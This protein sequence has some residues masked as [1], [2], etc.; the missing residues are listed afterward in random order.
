MAVYG[1]ISEFVLDQGTGV[2]M[3]SGWEEYCER[4]TQ[5]F[6]ANAIDGGDDTGKARQKAIFLSS[7]GAEVYSLLKTLS[8]PNKPETKS[9][10]DLQKLVL[11]HL[12]PAPIVIAERY[13][14]YNRK[15]R[16]GENAAEF[17]K[18]LRRLAATCEFPDTFREEVIRDMLVIGLRDRETQ[19]K[20]LRKD[21]LTLDTAF[22]EAQAMER[23][24]SQIDVMTNEVHKT[25]ISHKGKPTYSSGSGQNGSSSSSQHKTRP[26]FS[27]G[28]VGHWKNQ[29][30]KKSS[31]S[32]RKT[33]YKKVKQVVNGPVSDESEI[34]E[35][36]NFANVVRMS[37]VD[38]TPL[39]KTVRKVPE[40][41]VDVCVCGS[42]I[43][44]E[45]DTGAS[46]SLISKN[47]YE[48]LKWQ[49]KIVPSN[50]VLST[51]TGQA[52][53]VV[54]ECVVS[55][56]Y[57]EKAYDNMTIF[58]V[59]SEGPPL[60]GRD[61]LARIP[62]D[63]PE[64]K[65]V[66]QE[67]TQHKIAEVKRKYSKLFDGKLGKVEGVTAK[68]EL[69]ED[70]V[71]K[72]CKPR[73][74]PFATKD[75][76]AAEIAALV[77]SGV[78]K[79]VDYSDWASPIVPV[80]KPSG[81]LRICGDF[82]VTVNKFLKIPEHPMPRVS[83][84]LAK[85]NG[86]QKFT[87]LDLS[88]AYQQVPLDEY[89]QKLVTINTHLGLFS[90]TR[91][92]F[93]ISAA[94]ALFQ[95]IMDKVLQGLECGCYLDDIVITGRSDAEHWK[96]LTLVLER[97]QRF[98]FR[99]QEA[100]CEF[101]QDSVKYLGQVV[102]QKGI[103]MDEEGVT[104]VKSA[105]EPTNKD[106]LRSFLG[107]VSHYRRFIK[108]VSTKCAP[109]NR[110]LRKDERW[111]WSSSC[112]E[113]FDGMKRDLA[114][115]DNVLVHYDPQAPLILSVDASPTGLGAVISH[116]TADGDRPIEFASRSLTVAEKN[117]SQIDREALAIMFGVRKFHQYLYGRKFVLWTD[118]KPLSHI[119]ALKKGIPGLAAARV[120]RWCLELSAYTY[121]VKH[122][123]ASTQGNV[124]ALSRLPLSEKDQQADI[125]GEEARAVNLVALTSL[126]VTA[127]QITQGTRTDPVLS[128]VTHF[129]RE[130]WPNEIQEEWKPFHKRRMELS[131]EEDCLLWGMRV[132][133]PG[134]FRQQLLTLLH[135]GHPGMV[136]M[137]SLARK[138]CWWPLL[139][140][141]IEDM[142]RRCDTCTHSL[143]L[144]SSTT[145]N[146]A[147]PNGP[148]QR[149][150]LDFA[151]YRQDH[152]MVMVDAH[153]KWPE[154]I[155]MPHGTTAKATI[156]ALRAVFGRYGL[157]TTVVSDNGPPFPSREFGSFLQANGI[158]QIFSPPYHP[159]TNGEAERFVRTF[160]EGMNRRLRT[161][162]NKNLC[163]HEFLLT[164]RTT[165]HTTTGITPSEAMFGRNIRTK[166]DLIR[167]D[168]ANS[169]LQKNPGH[170]EVKGYVV[171]ER[172]VVR[173]YR[174]RK[175]TWQEGVVI[176]K[177]SP[178]TYQVEIPSTEGMVIWKR[179]ADQM[180]S[181]GIRT[182]LERSL[183]V[184]DDRDL[185]KPELHARPIEI[186][187]EERIDD[188]P[189]TT[190]P[191][192][193]TE[194]QETG[195]RAPRAAPRPCVAAPADDVVQPRRSNR[196]R[197]L[198][199]YLEDNY[200]LY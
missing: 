185:G 56:V 8:S 19:R 181:S 37:K 13:V 42:M 167:P 128:R 91:V 173:D 110:L 57:K 36:S 93:G 41:M 153:S 200:E 1:H 66:Q 170:K 189:R 35:P 114:E 76:I 135:E 124:D 18:E 118:N 180:R 84:L 80:R 115:P 183:P 39:V 99:L 34:E 142:I 134:K 49:V 159:Q 131:I 113:A 79:K 169:V 38:S 145:N 136:R 4:M 184:E 24:R 164:Y 106:E 50:V 127:K 144:P 129:L 178:M 157:P 126:P 120:Q 198:P 123:P 40:L 196:P 75:L 21:N 103:R 2:S 43:Q 85:L 53:P 61:W 28:E 72:F 148:W 190:E 125:A 186:T 15:Q 17:V 146:W 194:L 6:L 176:H 166:L 132:V 111:I 137:K 65:S 44:M 162:S 27:C 69:S 143:P 138:H 175:P 161:Q 165:P 45:L 188:L 182:D 156:D 16:E 90:Y 47:L 163:L 86:G 70:A 94:P 105:P 179:H 51:V 74:V 87:K 100:K 23:A 67:T 59:E 112:Q 150:H 122:R 199:T 82:S 152:F 20:L 88:Q 54:G 77:E 151:Q 155:H 172:V 81:K 108:D 89:S 119:V 55:V 14:F 33:Q 174:S 60:L 64:I 187:A 168:L 32:Y 83:E 95:G 177:L 102:D 158:K 62:L 116:E 130:G 197:K 193:T 68:L 160:K 25:Y 98:G 9:L 7:V 52:L 73:P 29:C 10:D 5:Y 22:K 97:L 58:V 121:E 171:G 104:A 101:F 46:V 26:C 109:L 141:E 107:L 192:P 117:Y 11:D 63:W 96:N 30:P 140:Q 195:V 31:T 3:K 154:V 133:I 92:P 147:W 78:L 191:E 139:D 149:V 71:A 12:S 48:K